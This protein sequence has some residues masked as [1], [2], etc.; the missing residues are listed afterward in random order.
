MEFESGYRSRGD[1]LKLIVKVLKAAEKPMNR[2]Q[3]A[4]AIQRRKSP[5][6]IAMLNDLVADGLIS[7]IATINSRRN[8]EYTYVAIA[9]GGRR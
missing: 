9:R 2:A 6:I 1:T 7:E 3:I 4:R 8:L 5:G